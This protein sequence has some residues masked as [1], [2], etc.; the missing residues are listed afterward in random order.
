MAI[1]G[2]SPSSIPSDIALS[3]YQFD[4]DLNEVF[5]KCAI[6]T[7]IKDGQEPSKKD[8]HKLHKIF[9]NYNNLITHFT[10]SEEEALKK[11]DHKAFLFYWYNKFIFYTK[12]NKCLA[13]NM[14][15]AKVLASGYVLA[16]NPAILANLTQCLAQATVGRIDPHQNDPLWV[17][18]LWLQ[19]FLHIEVEDP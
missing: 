7:L 1:L 16:L 14:S 4:L 3:W 19:V 11:G 10:G 15:I 8:V 18:Q 2:I 13:E 17:F 12:L 5:D 6:E 9:F